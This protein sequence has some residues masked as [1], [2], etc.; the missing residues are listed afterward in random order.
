MNKHNIQNT[1]ADS[2]IQPEK[3]EFSCRQGLSTKCVQPHQTSV[4]L[5]I[6]W[7]RTKDDRTRLEQETLEHEQT[8]LSPRNEQPKTGYKIKEQLYSSISVVFNI[9][10]YGQLL[11][12]SKA[13]P[14]VFSS[15]AAG[16]RAVVFSSMMACH[17]LQ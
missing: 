15:K 3:E 14:T 7:S 6:G 16:Y 5:Y 17:F 11:H 10:F 2:T 13:S 9:K 8:Q 1:V 4:Y 12:S